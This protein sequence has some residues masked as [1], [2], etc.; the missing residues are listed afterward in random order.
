[1]QSRLPAGAMLLRWCL[2]NLIS[3]VICLQ[4][5]VSAC[6]AQPTDHY[7][8][9]LRLPRPWNRTKR[10]QATAA[11][12]HSLLSLPRKID[13]HWLRRRNCWV[14]RSTRRARRRRMRRLWGYRGQRIGEASHPGYHYGKRTRREVNT[15]WTWVCRLKRLCGYVGVRIGEASHPGP[16]Q[17]KA[18]HFERKPRPMVDV[19]LNEK[20]EAELHRFGAPVVKIPGDGWCLFH[21]VAHFMQGHRLKKNTFMGSSWWCVGKGCLQT[22]HRKTFGVHCSLNFRSREGCIFFVGN[23]RCCSRPK[24]ASVAKT[25]VGSGCF[26]KPRP[27][28]TM[29]CGIS[30]AKFQNVLCK[31][32]WHRK[33]TSNTRNRVH[34]CIV[35]AGTV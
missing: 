33:H 32:K 30:K 7:D 8:G 2:R 15:R 22:R 6:A 18:R 16:R 1:M 5:V 24:T 23:H 17:E 9:A 29:A 34:V 28:K 14:P 27:S 31:S 10:K 11:W 20:V 3:G 35:D 25:L 13:V 26:S 21:S 4:C 19:G 12:N